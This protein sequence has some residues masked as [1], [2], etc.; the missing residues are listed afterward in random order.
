MWIA[1]TWRGPL[2]FNLVFILTNP[3]LFL[4]LSVNLFIIEKNRVIQFV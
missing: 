3:V 1:G 4:W 2:V